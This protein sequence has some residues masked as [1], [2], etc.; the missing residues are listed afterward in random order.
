METVPKRESIRRT[1]R[2]R[3]VVLPVDDLANGT[4]TVTWRVASTDGHPVS[5]GFIFYVG[6]PSSISAVPVEADAGAGKFVEWSFGAVRFAWFASL[7][8]LIGL[9]AVRR[10]VWTPAVRAAG[11]GESPA[12]ARFRTGFRRCLPAVW[13]VL[14]VS[15]ILWMVFQGA[16]AGGALGVVGPAALRRRRGAAY[17]VRALLGDRPAGHAA[18][19]CSRSSPSPPGGRCSACD[20]RS[21]SGCW[22]WP[23]PGCAWR[24][25]LSGHARTDPFPVLGVPSLA[26]HLF[27][28]GVWVGGLAA[29]VFLGGRAWRAVDSEGRP[30]LLRQVVTRFSKLA[31]V[32]VILVVA[33]GMVNSVASL[34]SVSDLWDVAYGRVLTAK[35]VLLM[36]AL[37]IAARHLWVVPA[38]LGGGDGDGAKAAVGGFQRSSVAE[39]AVL[40]VA[41]ALAA[42]LVTLVPGRTLAEAAKGPVN[43]DRRIGD[44]TVQ[45][46]V[47]PTAVGPN[48]VH[49]T[50]IDAAGLGAASVSN[51]ESTLQRGGGPPEAVTMTLLSPG[52]FVGDVTLPEPDRYQLTVTLGPGGPSTTFTFQLRKP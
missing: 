9:V 2:N 52:H 46:F 49:L 37:V 11:L 15:G 36:V 51:V 32:G 30:G 40:G 29:L 18:S 3:T 12:A 23:W 42:A 48:Q 1:D 27:A 14:A 21:G 34:A 19:P 50:F 39:L 28:V 26:V 25:A 7:I 16:S 41:L 8:A 22:R 33:T 38:R 20:H 45:L 47:D 43:Q 4:Y 17:V 35:I 13:A 44:L 10:W 31:I 5:G 6:A 24:S